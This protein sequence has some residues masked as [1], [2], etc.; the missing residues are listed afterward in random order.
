MSSLVT[1][2]TAST[3]DF[4]RAPYASMSADELS[5]YFQT[6]TCVRYFPL[7]HGS[8]AHVER[9]DK[10]VQHEF[11]FNNEVHRLP[12]T[13][14]WKMNPSLDIEWLILL[15]KFYYA[16]DL[17]AAYDFTG[18]E[19]YAR[20]WMELVSSWIGDVPDG[21]IDSQVTGRRLQQWLFAYHYFIPG[22]RSTSMAPS[23]LVEFVQSINS[24]VLYLREHLTP[25]GNHRTIELYAIFLVAVMFPELREAM[26][27]LEFAKQELLKNM[28]QDLLGDGVHRE[29]STDYHHTVL[30]NYLRVRALAVLNRITLPPRYNELIN[31]AL[32]FSVYVHKPDGLIPAINDGDSNSYLSFL[33]KACAGDPNEHLL[34]VV[35]KGKEGSPPRERSKGFPDS[36]YYVLRGSWTDEPY[37]D[38]LY[39]LFD[40]GPLG[41]GSHGHYDLLNFEAAAYGHSLIVDPGRYTYSEDSS[42]G[43]NW[44]RVFKGTAYHNTVVVDGKDQ[45]P[46]CLGAPITPEPQARL[47]TFATADG[48]DF[49]HAQA[50]SHEYPVIHERMVFFVVPEYWIVSDLLQGEGC[51]TY[52]LRFHLAPRAQGRTTLRA[53]ENSTWVSSP[54]LLIAQPRSSDIHAAIEEGFVSAAYGVRQD[55]PIVKFTQKADETAFFH[56]VIYPYRTERPVL[57]VERLTVHDSHQRC[58]PTRATALKITIRSETEQ[59]CDYLFMA[60]EQPRGEYRFDD[61]V[62]R[63]QVLFLRKD[64]VGRVVN[65]QAEGL[66][67]LQVGSTVLTEGI[68]GR[69]RVSYRGDRLYSSTPGRTLRT[70]FESEQGNALSQ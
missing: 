8:P 6:R 30:K 9:A 1:L 21:F 49:I 55:A 68:A 44:R 14:D 37:E 17:A 70:A 23:F 33:K 18:E 11:E 48:F 62:C 38:G 25:E 64:H 60:H 42:D 5:S 7:P 3:L 13:F 56:T 24:Q 28:E 59:Y 51:H 34:Y 20:K 45:I 31:K 15:H 47:K 66:D 22:R 50:V 40:C 16:K 36:G 32:E 19:E 35:S 65:L 43:V 53:G 26:S 54:N 41:F 69:G 52:D 2:S 12:K 57:D 58:S 29:L 63:S 61:I 4:L 27:L 10:I 67:H 39:L 46:Y